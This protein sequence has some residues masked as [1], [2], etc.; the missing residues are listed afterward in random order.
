M[1]TPSK[2]LI[3]RRLDTTGV[4][5]ALVRDGAGLQGTCTLI[6]ATPVPHTCRYEV[7]TDGTG[8][9]VRFEATVEGAGF[10]RVT[11]LERAA[12]RWRVTASE[13]GD[14]DATLRAAGHSRAGM[15]GA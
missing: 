11:R 14:L 5:Q 7:L 15:P 3:W 2:A 12:G 13:Q 1:A 9:T 6:A 8:A 10:V 4:E